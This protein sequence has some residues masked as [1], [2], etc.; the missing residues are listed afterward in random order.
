MAT[1]ALG[2]WA[3]GPL[4]LAAGLWLNACVVGPTYRAPAPPLTPVA[5]TFAAGLAVSGS[6]NA[7]AVSSLPVPDAWWRLYGDAALDELVAR[8]LVANT[9][10]RVAA[11]NLDEARALLSEARVARFP[12]TTLS[13]SATHDRSS[14]TPGLPSA[15]YDLYEGGIAASYEI[16]LFGRVTRMIEAAK[17][18]RAAAEAARDFTAT[19]VTAGVVRAYVDACASAERAAI[20]EHTFKVEQDTLALTQVL[21]KAGRGQRLDVV[22]AASLAEQTRAAIPPLLAERT[23]ALARLSVLTGKPPFEAVEAA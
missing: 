3:V 22:R 17:A 19:T 13:A 23:S 8:S 11:A 18:D 16:D 1:R 5:A 15:D 14:L 20:A 21:F 6:V 9:D 12:S 4:A 2:R 7:D 10:L